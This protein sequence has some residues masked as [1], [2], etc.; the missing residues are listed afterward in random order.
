[1]DWGG[2]LI[3][4]L[5]RPGYD[6]RA[7]LGPVQGH[8]TLMRATGDTHERLGTFHPEPPPVAAITAGLRARFDP[9]GIL[10]RGLMG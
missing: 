10:N 8:A 9:R 4:L 7:A 1:M 2:G 5:T 6:L 3:W